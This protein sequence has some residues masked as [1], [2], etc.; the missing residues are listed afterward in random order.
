[1]AGTYILDDVSLTA[2]TYILDT[3]L[4]TCGAGQTCSKTGTSSDPT[5]AVGF[6]PTA[7]PL[8]AALSLFAGGLGVIGLLGSR[9]KRKAASIA[10]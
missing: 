4:G 10:A 7:T 2:G 9:R 8:P 5:Y 6:A 3:Y 1:M